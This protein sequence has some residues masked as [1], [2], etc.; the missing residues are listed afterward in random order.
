M[1]RWRWHCAVV[2][3]RLCCAGA[4][5]DWSL[6]LLLSLLPPWVPAQIRGVRRPVNLIPHGTLRAQGALPP[7]QTHSLTPPTLFSAHSTPLHTHS[8]HAQSLT[9]TLVSSA[10]STPPHFTHT[11]APRLSTLPTPPHF[12]HTLAHAR[13]H[14]QCPLCLPYPTLLTVAHIHACPQCPLL[15]LHTSISPRQAP[16]VVSRP[17]PLMLMPAGG[18]H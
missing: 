11:H 12:L 5:T 10:H 15:R 6:L 17:P 4:V 18:Y 8:L 3:F 1:R 2:T 14:P 9:P 16:R 7:P 13:A